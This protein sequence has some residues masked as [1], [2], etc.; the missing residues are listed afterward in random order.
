MCSSTRA[1]QPV[2]VRGVCLYVCAYTDREV[3]LFLR[4]DA[5]F[6]PPH[7]ST[8]WTGSRDLGGS[9][10]AR[11]PNL[12]CRHPRGLCWAMRAHCKQAPAFINYLKLT[13]FSLFFLLFFCFF[14]LNLSIDRITR[15][16]LG[17]HINNVENRNRLVQHFLNKRGGGSRNPEIFAWSLEATRIL[18]LVLSQRRHCS[19]F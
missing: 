7:H 9:G 19:L 17:N 10:G 4:T 2:G 15:V 3:R 14:F 11:P 1:A 13:S 16:C 18:W 6:W 12:D 8:V 5:C